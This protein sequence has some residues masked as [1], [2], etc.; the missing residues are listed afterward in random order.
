MADKKT[1]AT[2]QPKP[3]KAK[4]ANGVKAGGIIT[5][6][7]IT[8]LAGTKKITDAEF[9]DQELRYQQMRNDDIKN[10]MKA[11]AENL[12]PIVSELTA[13][14]KSY[15]REQCIMCAFSSVITTEH[16]SQTSEYIVQRAVELG[17]LMFARLN[18]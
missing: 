9:Q 2:E 13:I 14:Q 15:T 4:A 10:T 12:N 16:K 18:A 3:K 8:P 6:T 7:T 17:D 11:V 1:V 5:A